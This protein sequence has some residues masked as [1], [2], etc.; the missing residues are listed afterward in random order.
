MTLK[1]ARS[2]FLK[3]GAKDKRAL[4]FVDPEGQIK[5]E[6]KNTNTESKKE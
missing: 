2:N 5:Y 3:Y 4:R 6:K 1:E